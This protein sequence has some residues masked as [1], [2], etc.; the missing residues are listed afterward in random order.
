MNPCEVSSPTECV[1]RHLATH[2]LGCVYIPS[3][4]SEHLD[5]GTLSMGYNGLWKNGTGA[6]IYA[7]MVPTTAVEIGEG[8][9]IGLER[10]ITKNSGVYKPPSSSAPG[11]SHST[12]YMYDQCLL[13]G[14]PTK[15]GLVVQLKLT[16]GQIA[17]I[18]WQSE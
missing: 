13:S 17:V 3:Q 15:G 10:T 5:F 2:E 12:I 11:L 8:F 6:N 18:V 4:V 14:P 16:L 7:T 9:V 1:N